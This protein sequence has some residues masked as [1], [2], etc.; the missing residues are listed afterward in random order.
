VYRKD[1]IRVLKMAA[2]VCPQIVSM[3]LLSLID[4][5]KH[6]K[7]TKDPVYRASLDLCEETIFWMDLNIDGITL[8]KSSKAPQVIIFPS[9]SFICTSLITRN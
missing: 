8:F 4:P 6:D 7:A 5:Q 2:K 1:L 9:Y 3:Q